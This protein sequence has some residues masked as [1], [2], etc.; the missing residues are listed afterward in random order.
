MA[1]EYHDAVG[2][3]SQVIEGR[4]R[5]T[6]TM[7]VEPDFFDLAEPAT[8][9]LELLQHTGSFKPRGAFNKILSAPRNE[10]GVIAA[11][12]GNH[13]AA[14]AFVA[15][16][17][18]IPAE[19]FVPEVAPAIKIRAMES[20]GAVVHVIEGI[21][22]NA[23]VAC[24]ARAE[25]SGALLVHAF[26]DPATI[27]GQGT[28]AKEIAEQVPDV[29][30]VLVA[31]GGGGLAAGA[32]DWFGPNGPKVVVVEPER[33]SCY[34][35]ARAAGEPVAVAASGV[36]VDS[37]GAGTIGKLAF[38]RLMAVDAPSVT[39]PDEAIV[40]TQRRFWDRMRLVV[41]PGGATA[42]AALLS[43]RYVPAPGERVVAVVCGANCDPATVLNP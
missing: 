4:V 19:I 27:A 16:A 8:L 9:K 22:D 33:S 32:A 6:P 30:T 39:V 29:D 1:S 40:M 28:M 2:T 25:Q 36:A 14:V 20:F 41:E 42:P 37:L 21:Y 34:A 31:T 15:Q 38:D 23:Y 24:A 26:N 11:S 3:A 7:V 12:G 13:G 10:A 35:A 17:V 43:R 18:G 5:R